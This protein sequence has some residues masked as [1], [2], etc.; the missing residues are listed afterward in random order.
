MK[1]IVSACLHAFSYLLIFLASQAVVS[2]AAAIILTVCFIPKA[3]AQ[4][5]SDTTAITN[6]LMND[7]F[8]Q[9]GLISII[10]YIF[11]LLV[12]LIVLLCKKRNVFNDISISRFNPLWIIPILVLGV[13]FQY[14]CTFIIGLIPTTQWMISDYMQNVEQ[15]ISQTDPAMILTV[16][17]CAPIVEEIIFRGLIFTR[18]C[19]GM[20]VA[21]AV[22]VA[23]LCFGISHVEPLQVIYATI[24][25]V[26][27]NLLFIKFK[28]IW[29]NIAL[30][31]AI[32]AS[33]YIVTDNFV[34]DGNLSFI[35]LAASVAAIIVCAFLIIKFS[36]PS[37]NEQ[38]VIA[39]ILNGTYQKEEKIYRPAY[40][41]AMPP[42]SAENNDKTSK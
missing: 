27:L 30:H 13:A 25:G 9:L 19:K 32:N 16:A 40:V 38:T 21:A 1:K 20:P 12:V 39:R 15:Y 7:V 41:Y 14:L 4:G 26:I 10:S 3:A 2:A 17:V 5:M 28:S 8:S 33:N 34:L 23:S 6:A 11:A 42:Q 24:F 31:F 22:I 35:L 18:L 37:G 29:A 36:K